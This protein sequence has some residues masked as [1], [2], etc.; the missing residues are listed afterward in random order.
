MSNQFP[1]FSNTFRVHTGQGILNLVREKFCCIKSQGILN[2]PYLLICWV[3]T[4]YYIIIIDCF[5]IVEQDENIHIQVKLS[6]C[7]Y[8][9]I[10]CQ[11]VGFYIPRIPLCISTKFKIDVIWILTFIS[12][13]VSLY[14]FSFDF[15]D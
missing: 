14:P 6:I 13:L 11:L 9:E 4:S 5:I 12:G 8:D 15:V 10:A 1:R 7:R 2:F 3:I